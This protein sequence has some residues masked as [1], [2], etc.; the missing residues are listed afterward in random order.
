MLRIKTVEQAMMIL[1]A[2]KTYAVVELQGYPSVRIMKSDLIN[3]LKN[4]DIKDD[5]VNYDGNPVEWLYDDQQ[6]TLYVPAM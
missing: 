2:S 5:L 3:S 6:R 1:K 4:H